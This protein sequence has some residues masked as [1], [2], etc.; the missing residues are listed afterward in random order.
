[1]FYLFISGTEVSKIPGL[2]AAGANPKVIPLTS[3]AD[4]DVIRFGFPEAVDCFPMDPEGHP[5]PA[6]ITRAAVVESGFPVCV[7]RAGAYLPPAAPYVETGAGYGKNPAIE[8]SVP[9]AKKIYD[10]SRHFAENETSSRKFVMLAESIPGGTTTALLTLRALGIDGMVSSGGPDN[11][12]SLKEKI[13]K[14]ASERVGIKQG[15]FANDPLRAVIELGDPMQAS[16]LGFIAGLPKDTDIV[17][18]G[19]T[20]MIA[21]AALLSKLEPSRAKPLIAT[22]KYVAGDNTSSF[23]ELAKTLGLETYAAQLDFSKSPHKGLSDYEKGYVKEGVGAGGS[24]LY[25][26]RLGV[27]VS[28]VIERTDAIYSRVVGQNVA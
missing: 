28:R 19:G 21:V 25:A 4:A 5:T 22:T 11:P 9:D 8:P 6:I 12:I 10:R 14:D 23:R 2:S 20:Q 27:S 17:L 15:D 16:V 1:M 3:P 13:W 24:I 26:E 18:A 7:I